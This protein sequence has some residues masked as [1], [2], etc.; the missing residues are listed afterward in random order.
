MSMT[1]TKNTRINKADAILS[2]A[3]HLFLKNGYVETTMDAIATKADMT[4]QTVYSYYSTKEALFTEIITEFCNRTPA[5]K[6]KPLPDDAPFG[7][8]L[9]AV[10]LRILDLITTEEVLATT[11]LVIAEA[12]RYPKLAKMYYESGTQRLVHMLAEFLDTQNRL[13]KTRIPNTQSAASY[14]LAMLKGQYYLRMILKI[15]PS[16]SESL[17]TAHVKDTVRVFLE[18]YVSGTPLKTESIL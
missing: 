3:R 15:K 1:A 11:R 18:L 16:P 4:K 13:G 17:K 5:A 12:D 2:A 14:F 7:A 8:L 6:G 10:G 9:E